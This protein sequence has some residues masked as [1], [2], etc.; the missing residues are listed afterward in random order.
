MAVLYGFGLTLTLPA[1]KRPKKR[2]IKLEGLGDR[3]RGFK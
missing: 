2:F 1:L 3:R